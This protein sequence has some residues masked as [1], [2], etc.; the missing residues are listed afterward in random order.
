MAA[1]DTPQTQMITQT[2]GKWPWEGAGPGKCHDSAHTDCC[3]DSRPIYHVCLL[4][5]KPWGPRLHPSDDSPLARWVPCL[6]S[7]TL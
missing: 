2:R 5:E 1:A 4:V 7:M 3:E 6:S